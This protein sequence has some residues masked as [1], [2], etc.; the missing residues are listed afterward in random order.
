MDNPK[1]RGGNHG[2][3]TTVKTVVL[4]EKAARY[5]KQRATILGERYRKEEA[6]STASTI[7]EAGANDRLIYITD[8]MIASISFLMD[9]RAMC[10]S[11][12]AQRGIDQL[13]AALETARD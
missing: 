4:S 2:G 13:I 9:A 3:G 10:F 6:N 11:E 5:V 7:L 12:T 1:P 8:D